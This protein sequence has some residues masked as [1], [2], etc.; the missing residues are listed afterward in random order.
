M[1]D[2]GLADIGLTRDYPTHVRRTMRE[3]AAKLEPFEDARARADGSRV[4]HLPRY[5]A[6]FLRGAVT[7]ANAPRRR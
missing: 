3:A 5:R 7:V 2:A 4:E 1:S 6:A